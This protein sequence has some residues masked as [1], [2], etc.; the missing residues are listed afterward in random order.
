[1]KKVV[2]GPGQYDIPTTIS[3]LP[4]YASTSKK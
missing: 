1:M 2:P 4:N 3:N